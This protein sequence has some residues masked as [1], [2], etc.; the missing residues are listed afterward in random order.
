M[1]ACIIQEN[2]ADASGNAGNLSEL[3]L[4]IGDLVQ[5]LNL[6]KRSVEL[7]DRSHDDFERVTKRTT[8]A[9]TLFYANCI[10][11]AL[12][13][14][15][16]AEE[17]QKKIER[18]KT[19]LYSLSGF[20]YCDL[21]LNQGKY[22]VVQVR[23]NQTIKKAKRNNWLLELALDNLSLGRAYLLQAEKDRSGDF[24]KVTDHLNKAVDGLRQAGNQPYLPRGLLARA[25]LYRVSGEFD[26]AKHD[27]DEAIVIAERGSMGL[28]QAD[29][30]IGY[31]QLHL[32]IGEKDKARES[33]SKAKIMIDKLGYHLRDRDVKE[34]KLPAP[35][36][37]R[38]PHQHMRRAVAHGHQLPRLPAAP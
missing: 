36:Y 24:I 31:A 29:C 6:S 16:K 20:E 3:Y 32:A 35:P 34:S 5:A 25:E 4:I 28:H 30:H 12:A 15:R 21:L 8:L 18:R 38:L 19:F 27:L 11:D 26:K 2:W 23:A 13:T 9:N 33:L 22:Q 14:Y 1:E 37:H 7:A 17:M 10:D